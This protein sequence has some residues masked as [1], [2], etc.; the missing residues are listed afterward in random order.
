[1]NRYDDFVKRQ[2]KKGKKRDE[3]ATARHKERE[4]RAA[5]RRKAQGKPPKKKRKSKDGWWDDMTGFDGSE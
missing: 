4:E 3:R 5:A 1:M 2:A